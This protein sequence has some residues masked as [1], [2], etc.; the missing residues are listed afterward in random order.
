MRTTNTWTALVRAR[1]YRTKRNKNCM[2]TVCP[3]TLEIAHSC[4]NVPPAGA[5][6][7]AVA[8]CVIGGTPWIR[9]LFHSLRYYSHVLGQVFNSLQ[10]VGIEN[11]WS[12][13]FLF[14]T[15]FLQ[16]KTNWFIKRVKFRIVMEFVFFFSRTFFCF[17]SFRTEDS[18]FL[19]LLP[20]W[21]WRCWLVWVWESSDVISTW[22]NCMIS[23][24]KIIMEYTLRSATHM[25]IE[26]IHLRTHSHIAHSRECTA[27][28][29]T[30]KK[31]YRNYENNN[32]SSPL[33]CYRCTLPTVHR[34]HHP[35]QHR[36][37][38]H[39]R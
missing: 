1:V 17:H 25:Y 35:C 15:Q 10:Q 37:N 3:S 5:N 14:Y 9:I 32:N 6:A 2:K 29:P 23:T 13:L 19:V 27:T 34:L 22:R 33:V 20:H 39:I 8:L 12:L 4:F 7:G 24:M 31:L 26:H 11:C 18:T 30:N 38:A 16:L 21:R 28:E 36:H